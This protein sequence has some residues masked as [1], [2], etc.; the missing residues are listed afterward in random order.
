MRTTFV[1]P[2]LAWSVKSVARL[3]THKNVY[4]VS[5][6]FGHIGHSG[7]SSSSYCPSKSGVCVLSVWRVEACGVCTFERKQLRSA[8]AG[9]GIGGLSKVAGPSTK[10]QWSLN[11]PGS[12]LRSAHQSCGDDGGVRS[13]W[14]Q[15]FLLCGRYRR[16]PPLVGRP[17]YSKP[18]VNC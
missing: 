13:R 7:F 8:A 12:C 1:N 15:A 2:Q 11:R 9:T 3:N 16:Q 4:C 14:C 5:I 10:A 6:P 18:A 17:V